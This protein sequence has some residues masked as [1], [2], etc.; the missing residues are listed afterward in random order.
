M[1]TKKVCFF[2]SLV[3]ILFVCDQNLTDFT[4]ICTSQHKNISKAHLT[5]NKI[6][7]SVSLSKL[8]RNM[9]GESEKECIII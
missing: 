3:S 4:V 7:T 1:T 6:V 9:N 5:S 8:I 2:L